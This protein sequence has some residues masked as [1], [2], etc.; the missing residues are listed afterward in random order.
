MPGDA[1]EQRSLQSE[2]PEVCLL[3]SPTFPHVSLR[4]KSV[5]LLLHSLHGRSKDCART[6]GNEEQGK[7]HH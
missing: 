1:D 5:Q 7:T 4:P 2:S 6:D 3:I